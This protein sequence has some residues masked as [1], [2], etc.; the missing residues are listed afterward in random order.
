MKQLIIMVA[1]IILAAAM[2]VMIAGPG[3][4]SIYSTVSRA[5]DA[6]VEQR[7]IVTE[8]GRTK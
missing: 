3:D 7:N 5:W 8:P 4:D 1:S 2:F 6:E